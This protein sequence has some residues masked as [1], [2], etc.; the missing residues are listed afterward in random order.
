M[1][2]H[3]T[4]PDQ[5]NSPP[6]VTRGLFREHYLRRRLPADG[7]WQ[8]QFAGLQVR[9]G[10]Q[11]E[12]IRSSAPRMNEATL[13]TEW[14]R[15]TLS[16]IGFGTDLV[17]EKQQTDAFEPDYVLF[18]SGQDRDRAL[19]SRQA[20]GTLYE[21][22]VAL[23]E[24]KA[25][26]VDLDAAQGRE[27]S[28]MSQ[29]K[30]YL[31]ESGVAWGILTNGREWRLVSR[32]GSADQFYGID[33]PE[34]TRASGEDFKYFAVI[35]SHAA[36]TTGRLNQ[37]RGESL[38]YAQQ[39]EDDLRSRVREALTPLGQ[40]LLHGERVR[41]GQPNWRPDSEALQVLF[42]A[43]MLVLYRALFA[44]YAESRELLPLS[45]PAY[46]RYSL[47]SLLEDVATQVG[48]TR[49][50]A[51]FAGLATGTSAFFG[52]ARALWELIERGEGAPGEPLYVPRYNGGLFRRDVPEGRP[53]TSAARLLGDAGFG[54]PDRWFAQVLDILARI[55]RDGQLEW[56]DYAELRER[57]LGSI[58]EGLLELAF[59][60]A[61][62]P[63]VAVRSG[64]RESW[65]PAD[66]AEAGADVVER[67]GPGDLYVSTDSNE[68]R[69]TGAFYTPDWVVDYIVSE[70]VGPLFDERSRAVR[71]RLSAATAAVKR[72]R[73]GSRARQT[74]E[75]NLEELGRTVRDQL[76]D[77]RVLD[78]AMG[79]GHF[80]VGAVE[81]LATR[82]ATDPSYVPAEGGSEAELADLRRLV[83]ERCIYGVDLSY[84]AVELTKLSLWLRTMV[85][86]KPLDFLDHHLRWGNSLLGVADL[87]DLSRPPTSGAA[88]E[89]QL[90]FVGQMADEQAV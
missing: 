69:A 77:L 26:N 48:P 88:P 8:E 67:V 39:L 61:E 70:T 35:F 41:R 40:G 37:I 71:E 57:Q 63:L 11:L 87:A 60:V 10:H 64:G 19:S 62:A 47:R 50:P 59:R 72:S 74:A 75:A 68:R 66:E 5:A 45:A 25:W 24:A 73:R 16:D 6:F 49:E 76:L 44:A 34:L 12:R 42:D 18:G 46:R 36:L 14:I 82:V 3:A 15:P 27:R 21:Q 13:E 7:A 32:E 20:G 4:V 29:I 89:G 80:L 28:P 23:V 55:E 52:R 65:L 79:S 33:L 51:D 86:G 9:L 54:I 2:V 85:F 83:A 56:V 53:L 1:Q 38:R 43:A 81:Y 30:R 84:L 31:V 17:I 90:G 78:P 58:Y 22:A